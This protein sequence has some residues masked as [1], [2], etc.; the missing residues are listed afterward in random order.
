M[1]LRC[2]RMRTEG[3]MTFSTQDV[4]QAMPATCSICGGVVVDGTALCHECAE[5]LRWVRGYF[6]HVSGLDMQITPQTLFNDLGADS[7]D[8]MNWLLAG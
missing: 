1:G 2:P 3:L 6:A 4:G 7:L 5:L 8:W